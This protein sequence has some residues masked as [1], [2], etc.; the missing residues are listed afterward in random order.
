MAA[1]IARKYGYVKDAPDPSDIPYSSRSSKTTPMPPSFSLRKTQPPI[2]DQGPLGS[3]VGEG[4]VRAAETVLPKKQSGT[5][6]SVLFAYW[7][8]RA[9]EDNTTVDCGCQIRDGIA[10]FGKFGACVNAD[11]PYDAS[12]VTVQP[13]KAAFKNA[14]KFKSLSKEKIG[15]FGT[16][17]GVL[18]KIKDAVKLGFPVVYG[19]KVYQS[20]EAVGS[21]G[22]VPQPGANEPLLGG[23]CEA[24]I[25]WNDNLLGDGVGYFEEA[26]SWG[27]GWGDHGYDWIPYSYVCSVMAMDLWA[28]TKME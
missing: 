11:W 20:F 1:P 6:L 18:G 3:C 5:S 17:P 12:K 2:C 25:G 13:S 16:D 10:A 14:L 7:N 22:V 8:A 15:E 27:T 23:H 21:N 24:I 4:C 19:K 9:L 28:I 26:N